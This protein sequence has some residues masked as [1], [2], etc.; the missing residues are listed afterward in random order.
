M[1]LTGV[2][3]HDSES[4]YGWGHMNTSFLHVCE[5]SGLTP[6]IAQ[7]NYRVA[8]KPT[9]EKRGNLYKVINPGPK[10]RP[11]NAQA[12]GS[13]ETLPFKNGDPNTEKSSSPWSP[14]TAL[15]LMGETKLGRYSNSYM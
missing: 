7:P 4:N 15:G 3:G 10:F 8:G 9:G 6:S 1:S 12:L 13:K 11:P 2:T 14:I 5:S